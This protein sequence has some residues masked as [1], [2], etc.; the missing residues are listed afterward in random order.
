MLGML[1]PCSREGRKLQILMSACASILPR[2][3]PPSRHLISS[4]IRMTGTES[5]VRRCGRST[6]G[7]SVHS[8]GGIRPVGSLGI[9]GQD[10]VQEP[11]GPGDTVTFV[12]LFAGSC[13]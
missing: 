3:E 9:R 5:A 2:V 7:T 10:G 11:P 6:R 8:E 4:E 13:E 1:M 12:R